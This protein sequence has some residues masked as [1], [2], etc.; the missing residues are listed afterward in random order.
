MNP[1]RDFDWTRKKGAIAIA[2][3]LWLFAS[4][5]DASL[6]PYTSS[7]S[8]G[9]FHPNVNVALTS[10]THN[11]TSINIPAGVTVTFSGHSLC[12]LLATGTVT[13]DGTLQLTG[14]NYDGGGGLSLFTP[15]NISITGQIDSNGTNGGGG[16]AILIGTSAGTVSLAG[17]TLQALASLGDPSPSSLGAIYIIAN[18]FTNDAGFMN[19][20]LYSKPNTNVAGF[21][22]LDSIGTTK[23]ANIQ[24]L[25]GNGTNYY[26]PP[27][28]AG[29]GGRIYVAD[30]PPP[31]PIILKNATILSNSAF[32][33]SFTNNP[34]LTFAVVASTN[35]SLAR[36]NWTELG[37][38]TEISPGQFQFTDTE[39]TNSAQRFYSVHSP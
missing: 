11:F 38:A 21:A 36:S 7:G 9:A 30:D 35:V 14:E 28:G 16:G 5:A 34:G 22:T 12:M 24:M 1:K 6:I 17:G 20:P 4:S 39:I 32:Q 25:P 10:G 3:F 13:I 27:L 8:E 19:P 2:L 18:S 31:G 26:L 29:A 15:G 37:S 33:F 23:T